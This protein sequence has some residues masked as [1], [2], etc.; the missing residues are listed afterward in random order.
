M[1]EVP[2]GILVCVSG[3]FGSVDRLRT[4]LESNPEVASGSRWM[5]EIRL[6]LFDGP[7]EPVLDIVSQLGDKA[8]VSCR[9]RR[10]GGRFAGSESERVALLARAASSGAGFVDVELSTWQKGGGDQIRRAC[11][12]NTRV[13]LSVHETVASG[14]FADH[15]ARLNAS[16]VDAVKLAGTVRNAA[17]LI[18]LARAGRSLKAPFTSVVGMGPAAALT[19]MR[20]S[21]FGGRMTYASAGL[22]L[23][24]ADG[25]PDFARLKSWR[26][27]ESDLLLPVALVGG[28]QISA[29]P[30][31]DILNRVFAQRSIPMQYFPLPAVDWEQI[32]DAIGIFGIRKLAVTMPFKFKPAK[33]WPDALMAPEVRRTGVTNTVIIGTDGRVSLSN[34]D[35]VGAAELF[36]RL[37]GVAGME[38]LILGGGAT[39][40]SISSAALQAGAAVTVSARNFAVVSKSW[41]E[42]LKDVRF[43]GWERRSE[44]FHDVVINT[45]P[46][47]ADRVSSAA[48]LPAVNAGVAAIDVV[49]PGREPTG[50]ILSAGKARIKFA[51]GLDFWCAQAVPQIKLLCGI[52][53]RYEDLAQIMEQ[54]G[55]PCTGMMA[56]YDSTLPGSSL[57]PV[58]LSVP[59]SKSITQ[60]YLVLAATARYPSRITNPSGSRDCREMER[61]LS[62]MGVRFGR[63]ADSLDV[64]PADF[65][66][67]SGRA[68]PTGEGGTTTRFIAALALLCDFEIRLKPSGSM[69]ERPMSPLFE[70][71][72]AAGVDV[73]SIDGEIRLRRVSEPPALVDVD[74]GSS[75]Q[76]ASALLMAGASLD[77]GISIA[78]RGGMVSG[79]YLEMTAS[80]IREF[81]GEVVVEGDVWRAR[82]L[83]PIQGLRVNVEGDASLAAFWQAAALIHGRRIDIANMP[84][85]AGRQGT[86]L[87]TGS[88]QGTGLQG[89]ACYPALFARLL[90]PGNVE[91]DLTDTPD[92]L[93]PLALVALFREAETV[94]SGIAHARLKESDRLHVLARELV[95]VGALMVEDEDRLTFNPSRLRGPAN[96]DPDGD[97]RMAMAFGIL[98]LRVPGLKIMDPECV[99]KSYPAFWQD[100]EMVR[101]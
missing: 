97:H 101:N 33:H 45:T 68:I 89:D 39:S 69:L 14:Y 13:M 83:R 29:S 55:H 53:F 10:D 26:V 63:T 67:D 70:A 6:D 74:C 86:G 16:G 54:T 15:A 19:R 48:L 50:L 57:E 28:E 64:Y 38:M 18:A 76:F 36:D 37:G 17:D 35:S 2:P 99:D 82:G 84:G 91:L 32:V 52:D 60:R 9:S 94:F 8:V 40:R 58:R 22:G 30:G 47:G 79:P 71:L 5:L 92:L 24:T 90:E 12:G 27:F 78:V 77:S 51:S 88:G 95:K 49:V 56:K 100:L 4:F 7:I 72:T 31:P 46:L 3:G 62:M 66:G 21:A 96:L 42:S 87:S 20:P 98:S 75:S 59:G 73:K 41:P 61:A 44:G 43:K 81:G 34:T 85:A 1:A 80:A 25:Q 65:P 11:S 93:P 23:A